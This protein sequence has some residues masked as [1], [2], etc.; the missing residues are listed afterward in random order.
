MSPHRSLAGLALVALMGA[1]LPLLGSTIAEAAPAPCTA[2]AADSVAASAMAQRCGSRV[3]ALSKRTETTVGFANPDGT[4]TV[5]VHALA[6]RAR[7]RDGSWS[8]L[9]TTLQVNADNTF[10]PIASTVDLTLSG[11]GSG[12]LLKGNREGT[13]FGLSWAGA[14]PKPVVSGAVATYPEVYP[15]VDLV[16]TALETGF[17]EVL[18]VKNRAAAT[19]PALR[20]IVFGT[21]L[22]GGLRWESAEGGLRVVDASGKAV[23]SAAAPAMWDSTTPSSRRARLA[24]DE[25]SVVD[26]PDR[27]AVSRPGKAARQAPI[28]LSVA[29]GKLTLTPD[30]AMLS[31]PGTEYPVYVD[32]TIAYTSWAM[33]SSSFP[34]QEYWTYDKT[35][36]PPEP[37]TG[38]DYLTECAKVGTYSVNYRSMFQ[39]ATSAYQGKQILGAIFSL[40]LL[41]SAS[42]SNQPTELRLVDATLGST[43][44]WNNTASKWA[45][46]N[47]TSVSNSSC[48]QARKLTEFNVTSTIQAAETGDWTRTTF[49]LKSANEAVNTSTSSQWKKFDAKKAKLVV[50][51]NT[52]PTAPA[53]VTVDNKSCVTGTNRPFIK[54][55]TPTVRAYFH[56][57]DGNSMT[58]T[59]EFARLRPTDDTYGT[60][61]SI[62]KVSLPSA[63]TQP[64]DLPKGLTGGDVFVAAGDWDKD[65]HPDV[66]SRDGLGDLFLYPGTATK[67]TQRSRVGTGWSGYAIAGMADWDKDGHQDIV[68]KDSSG[69]LWFYPGNSTRNGPQA[70]NRS[71]IGTGWGPYTLAGLADWDRDGHMDI[72]AIENNGDEWLYPGES[73]RTGSS[74]AR[75]LLGAGWGGFTPFGTIDW[76]GDGAPDMIARD[77]STGQLWLYPGSGA[78][79]Y[80]S[81]SPYRFE[82]GTGWGGY[83]AIITPDFNADGKADIVAKQPGVTDWFAYPG[84]GARTYG[85]ARWTIAGIGISDGSYAIRVKAADANATSGYSGWCEFTVD[86]QKPAMPTVTPDIYLEGTDVCA[87]GPCGSVG[88]TGRFIFASSSDVTQFRYWWHGQAAQTLT[89]GALGGSVPLD[90]TPTSGGAKT[91]YVTA[92]DRAGNEETKTYQFV[93]KAES[94]AIARWKMNDPTDSV[95]VADVSGNNRNATVTGATLGRPG[96]ILGGETAATFDG[97]DDALYCADF[98]NTSKT[99]SVAIWA[100]LD[101]KGTKNQ[102]LIS[103]KGT[104]HPAFNLVWDK[105]LDRW[106]VQVP[107]N[108]NNIDPLPTWKSAVSTSVPQIGV[109]THLA[110][111]YD[112]AALELRLYVNGVLEDTETGVVSINVSNT[113]RVGDGGGGYPWTGAA[114]DLWIWDRAIFP[115]EITELA[116]AVN[117]GKWRF[118]HGYD[119]SVD[120]SGYFHDLDYYGGVTIPADG[121]SGHDGT[122]LKLDGVD[123]YMATLDQVVHTDQTFTVSAWA[124]L[125][126]TTGHDVIV[127]QDSDGL[128]AGFY[129]YYQNDNGGEWVFGIRDSKTDT[130]NGTFAK[131]VAV[132]PTTWHHLTGVFDAQSKQVQLYVDGVLKA[133]TAMN[134]AW[135]P[136]QATGALQIGRALNGTEH[137]SYFHG[138]IDEVRAYQGIGPVGGP[139]GQWKVNEAAGSTTVADSSGNKQTATVYGATLGTAGKT[140]TAAQFDGINDYLGAPSVLDTS[141]SFSV[142]TWVKLDSKGSNDRTILS[143]TGNSFSAF[144]LQFDAASDRWRLE[145]SGSDTASP[146]WKSANSTSVPQ[147]GVWTHL[148]ATY[149][150][151]TK[152]LRLYV[153]GVL[154]GTATNVVTWNATGEFRIGRSG[155]T[156]WHGAIDEVNM[157]N[158]VISPAEVLSLQ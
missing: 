32:P 138:D 144:Y 135:Q 65:G 84:S 132:T 16:V 103:Q 106:A 38:R 108:D 77:P 89:P 15:G 59:A 54:T 67:L 153:S 94:P 14:L 80:Y 149:D 27:S 98:L 18:V 31:D 83:Q 148:A 26:G 128:N 150:A 79:G 51:T 91:L 126:S 71:Q 43:T 142:A 81:G 25:W 116:A 118:E 143:Q 87:G 24:A 17:S 110:W 70:G 23:L 115:K 62:S 36:C 117:V 123:D 102:S 8:K 33:I 101:A 139:L 30:L 109:W 140:G 145:V 156:W 45:G 39:F 10:S 34:D 146:T 82:I 40:D 136:W 88:K 120:E 63:T 92:I 112:S 3:E 12:Q 124:R 122:G 85:G 121:S 114:S 129:L 44:N 57:G 66:M 64:I 29:G 60:V 158:R 52:I 68:A 46:S 42:C 2:E 6:Q 152:E 90:W 56:D 147:V 131:A 93:V 4:E 155:G 151:N 72:I 69:V 19:N 55:D 133:T 9:D 49:G 61:E 157:W 28:G 47:I 130:A 75:V 111:V 13:E 134:A 7:K 125:A 137:T 100:R 96:R 20:E 107:S 1:G 76:D 74:Q 58:G 78:R 22:S 11:G 48:N 37:G 41:H 21:S 154:E 35:D 86:T 5:E 95:T 99:Y 50:T 113:I 104:N 73:K 97:V 119:P 105:G 141:K 53:S 127:S